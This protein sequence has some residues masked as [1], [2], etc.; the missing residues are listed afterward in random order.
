MAAR[1]LVREMTDPAAYT[2]VAARVKYPVGA[3]LI[4]QTALTFGATAVLAR[5]LGPR[6]FGEYALALTI[7]GIFQLVAAFP[8]ESG[9][10]KFLAEARSGGRRARRAGCVGTTRPASGAD[11]GPAC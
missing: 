9:T 10:P 1:A 7:A 4:S 11:W 3:M 6:G 8:V 5:A 2:L